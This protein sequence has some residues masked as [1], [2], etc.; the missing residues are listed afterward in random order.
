MNLILMKVENQMATKR[1]QDQ[2]LKRK[3]LS[4]ALATA[5][6]LSSAMLIEKSMLSSWLGKNNKVLRLQPRKFA[7]KKESNNA[8]KMRAKVTQQR[9]LRTYAP[10]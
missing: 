4:Q 2:H 5:S 3:T 6:S 10:T 9:K 1:S 8:L 7:T